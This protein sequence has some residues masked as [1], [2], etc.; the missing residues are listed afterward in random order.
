MVVIHLAG[1]EVYCHAQLPTV[2]DYS[3][4]KHVHPGMLD[5]SGRTGTTFVSLS[6]SNYPFPANTILET[7]S[8]VYADPGAWQN[9]HGS[10]VGD[11]VF[12]GFSNSGTNVNL[13]YLVNP[14]PPAPETRLQ[15]GYDFT[16]IVFAASDGFLHLRFNVV[17]VANTVAG[18][19]QEAEVILDGQWTLGQASTGGVLV[20]PI[21]AYAPIPFDVTEN[22]VYHAETNTTRFYA[23]RVV[24]NPGSAGGLA[25]RIDLIGA[26]VPSGGVLGLVGV[27]GVVAVR[28]RRRRLT[29]YCSSSRQ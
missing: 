2:A 21:S 15:Y 7:W 4:S 14:L 5:F 29:S 12:S 18:A 23:S 26:A 27:G 9:I 24:T 1:F 22:F 25:Y 8:W 19:L 28:R 3:V 13:N 11:A 16:P 6:L 17:A 10:T 20:T